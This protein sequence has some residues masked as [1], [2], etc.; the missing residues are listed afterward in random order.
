MTILILSI[1]GSFFMGI[2]VTLIWSWVK[3]RLQRIEEEQRR[4]RKRLL[5]DALI[6]KHLIDRARKRRN[7]KQTL[8]IDNTHGTQS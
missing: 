6:K 4:K 3:A 5:R 2:A 8:P 7:S 1:V